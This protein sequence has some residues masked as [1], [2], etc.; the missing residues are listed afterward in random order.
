M[1][2]RIGL[3]KRVDCNAGIENSCERCSLVM[4]RP[5]S[6]PSPGPDKIGASTAEPTAQMDDGDGL[7]HVLPFPIPDPHGIGE[8]HPLNLSAH[9]D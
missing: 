9:V 5:Q 3:R 2:V 7:G 6:A 8:M 1:V 4:R